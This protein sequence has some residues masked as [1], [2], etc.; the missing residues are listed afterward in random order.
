AR[1]AARDASAAAVSINGPPI[2]VVPRAPD[3][4]Q[5]TIDALRR[6]IKVLEDRA[7]RAE[8]QLAEAR[9]GG[10]V[11][12]GMPPVLTWPAYAPTYWPQPANWWCG[13]WAYPVMPRYPMAYVVPPGPPAAPGGNGG[14][15]A[16]APAPID[17]SRLKPADAS[18]L[19]WKGYDLYWGRDY[20]AAKEYL[21]AAAKLGMKDARLWYYKSLTESALGETEAAEDSLKRGA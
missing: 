15:A 19:F 11:G 14:V 3:A 20:A 21:A 8:E 13:A 12:G 2:P 9:R 10:G 18:R 16:R 1:R 17:V 4:M 7:R 5:K 6:R